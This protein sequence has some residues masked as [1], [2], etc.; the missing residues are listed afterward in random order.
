MKIQVSNP[1]NKKFFTEFDHKELIDLINNI[2]EF[3]HKPEYINQLNLAQRDFYS[4]NQSYY[5]E[6]ILQVMAR[7]NCLCGIVC[8][9]LDDSPPPSVEAYF[10][11]TYNDG[12]Y[13]QKP[14]YPKNVKK[15][16]NIKENYQLV[17][18]EKKKFMSSFY[19]K[20][21]PY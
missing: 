5:R 16:D 9:H 6:V 21:L 8:D 18:D 2:K 11:D 17:E 19:N 10:E 12:I 4:Q 3:E 14:L 15:P 7:L 13:W 1:Y 20:D